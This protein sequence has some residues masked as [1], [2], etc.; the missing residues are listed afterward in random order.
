L[1]ELNTIILAGCVVS[2]NDLPTTPSTVLELGIKDRETLIQEIV[3]RNPGPRLGEVKKS[4]EACGIE[5]ELPL[6]LA[7]L[8]RL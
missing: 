8:F 4:C 3:D 2:L 5:V 6:S 1:A 7:S